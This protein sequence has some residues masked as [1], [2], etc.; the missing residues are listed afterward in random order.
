MR[1]L[2]K[3]MGQPDA[4]PHYYIFF[5]WCSML[6]CFGSWRSIKKI[7]WPAT[8]TDNIV[9]PSGGF[10]LACEWHPSDYCPEAELRTVSYPSCCWFKNKQVF[11]RFLSSRIVKSSTLAESPLKNGISL[12]N[13]KPFRSA[14]RRKR[15]VWVQT[16]S[17]FS[18]SSVHPLRP[19]R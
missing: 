10:W 8:N 2:N 9:P 7:L 14:E 13:S 18:A 17:A 4:T 16:A 15:G 6:F 11:R 5:A 19:L 12:L 1:I 3:F